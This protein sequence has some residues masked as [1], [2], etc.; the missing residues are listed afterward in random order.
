M[1]T[2]SRP[3]IMAD[4]QFAAVRLESATKKG[5][6]RS[7]DAAA[8]HPGWPDLSDLLTSLGAEVLQ[9]AYLP[10][11][12]AITVSDVLLFDP[13]DPHSVRTDAIVLA[14]GLNVEEGDAFALVD[15]AGRQCAAAV[16]FRATPTLPDRIVELAKTHGLALLA[17]VPNMSWGHLY[18]LLRTAMVSAG[19]AGHEEVAGVPV[20]DLFALADAIAA[21]MGGA[22]TIEDPQWRVLAHSNLGHPIDDARRETILGRT[23]SP[24]WLQRIEESGIGR[25][26]RFGTDVVR[27]EGGLAPRLAAPVR[28]GSEL[29]ASI[30]VAEGTTPLGA[31]AEETL[32]RAAERAVVHLISHRSSDEIK[33]R[34]R[35]AFVREVLD[36]RLAPRA[37]QDLIRVRGPFTVLAFESA[38]GSPDQH[39]AQRDRILSIVTL[40]CENS[41]PESMCALID[42]RF[43][44]VVPLQQDHARERSLA[45]ADQV[46]AAVDSVTPV[47]LTAGIG[48][49]VATVADVPRSRRSAE[50]ALKVIARRDGGSRVVHVSDVRAHAVLLDMLDLMAESATLREGRL[51]D[52]FAGDPERADQHRETLRAYLDCSGNVADAAR[53]L[54]L[55]PNTLRYR[56]QRLVELSGL[57]LDDPDERLVTELQLRML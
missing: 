50:Q 39:L 15:T 17:A 53:R 8:P 10:P 33:R 43:W 44:A 40:Y 23:P 14:V 31:E 19:A 21:A 11:G 2:P 52:V 16:A 26:M 3:N 45:L 30:W 29:L 36:G 56:V 54:G 35:G 42:D 55:H 12:H 48:G 34:T 25:A 38:N 27:L 6:R 7:V 28:A 24:V 51:E 32:A 41:H 9:P 57:D 47:R 5:Y 18:S 13:T 49:S 1:E 20:G 37:G 46:L 22:V 4:Y